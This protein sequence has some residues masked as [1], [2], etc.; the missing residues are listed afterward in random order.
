MQI[1]FAENLKN[2]RKSMGLTQK[3]LAELMLVD[4]R[5]VS[6][7]ENGVCEPSFAVLAKLCEYFNETFDNILT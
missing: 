6:A 3:Q 1:K 2:L 5:T 7:W 4:Q